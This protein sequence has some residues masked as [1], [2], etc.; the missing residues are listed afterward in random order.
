M[1]RVA[2]FVYGLLCYAISLGVFVYGM[3]FIGGFLTPT[4]L[5]GAPHG[6]WPRHWRLIWGCSSCSRCSTASWPARHSSPGGPAS[7]RRPPSAAPTCW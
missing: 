3:G 7:S 2:I 4:M 5:D 6:R 1:S